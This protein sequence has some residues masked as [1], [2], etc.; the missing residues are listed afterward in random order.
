MLPLFFV[1]ASFYP[2]Q[3]EQ[4][5]GGVF[6]IRTSSLNSA[7]F[8][9]AHMAAGLLTGVLLDLPFLRRP[10]RA[11][12]GWGLLF[13]SSVVVW[14][15][16]LA[17]QL[18]HDRRYRTDDAAEDDHAKLDITDG[19]EVAG[20]ITL[21]IVHGAFNT[22]WQNYCYWIIGAESNSTQ[23]ASILVGVYE[24]L[25]AAGGTMAWVFNAH[26][27]QGMAQVIINWVLSM[28]ALLIVIPAAWTV[29]DHTEVEEM[30]CPSADMLAMNR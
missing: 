30:P 24:T 19:S 22:M 12:L 27:K 10:A 7:L 17:F 3:L 14:G 4:I 28:V 6:N 25:Q 8:S 29:T 23:I 11:R 5:N 21:F 20:P 9:L 16:A 18:D 13:F 15:G 1:A 26:G 2:Y